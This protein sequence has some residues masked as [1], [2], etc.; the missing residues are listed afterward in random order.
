MPKKGRA[1]TDGPVTIEEPRGIIHGVGMVLD[2]DAQTIKLKSAVRGTLQPNI[3]PEVSSALRPPCAAPRCRAARC[4]ALAG[5]LARRARAGAEKADREKP[6]NYSADTGDVNYQTQGRH[7]R[8]QRGHHAGHADDPRRPDRVPAEP[9]QLDV[10]HRVRQSGQPSARSATASTSTTRASRSAS[11]TTARRSCVELFDRALL[12]RGQDEIRSNYISYNTATEVFKA[13]G[14][15]G[16]GAR[17]RHAARARACA[18]CSS[19]SPTRRSCPAR[20]RTPARRADKAQRRSRR[21]S[22]RP[23]PR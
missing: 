9:R 8:R 18:A 10:G 15:A 19:R 5:V 21:P 4:V 6:I 23:R 14:R 3:A 20:A 1:E 22:R 17:L 11:S 13:E 16:I 7:A 2:N 12:Q